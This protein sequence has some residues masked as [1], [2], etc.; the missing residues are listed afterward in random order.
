MTGNQSIESLR[1]LFDAV[2]AMDTK[3]CVSAFTPDGVMH[4][5]CLPSPFPRTRRGA[6]DLEEV[7][8]FLF[9]SVFKRFSWIGLEIHATDDPNLVFARTRSSCELTDGRTYA[10][11][12]ACFALIDHGLVKEYTEFFDTERAT[13]AFKHLV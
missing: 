6:K 1:R 10:N 9:T 7:Y 12:Y 5:P 8:G 2:Q 11:E 4:T 3:A 13:G